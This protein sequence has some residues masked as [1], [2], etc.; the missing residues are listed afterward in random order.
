MLQFFG[1]RQIP[2]PAAPDGKRLYAI[3]DIHGRLDLLEQI[4]ATIEADARDYAGKVR[5]VFLGDY[6]DRGPDSRGV[7]E[8][9][10]AGP[11]KGHKWKCLMG[12][13]DALLRDLLDGAGDAEDVY[14]RWLEQGGWETMESYAVK[15]RDIAAGG[16]QSLAALRA[17]VPKSHRAFLEN[18][19]FMW[20]S[21]DYV[22]VHAGVRPGV[23]LDEQK[24]RDM[25]WIREE[26]LTH[27]GDFG[28]HVVHGHT[29]SRDIDGKR[30]RTGIDTGA[31]A[32]GRLTA[33][34][35]EGK[36]RRVLST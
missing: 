27:G 36:K 3:G 17:A 14:P 12:N 5:T 21:G 9:L 24:R 31:Y 33:L 35:L 22:F 6:I 20:R 28:G 29:I 13:H 16:K 15:R 11:P 23:A 25:I 8:R 26:F 30:N 19:K 10:I 7:I 32:T 34:V 18:L 4:L 1:N 2:K